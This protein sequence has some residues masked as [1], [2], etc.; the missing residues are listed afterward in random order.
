MKIQLSL[1]DVMAELMYDDGFELD[2]RI[3]SLHR[4]KRRSSIASQHYCGMFLSNQRLR[5]TP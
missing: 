3:F 5:V 2:Q 4:V 1:L